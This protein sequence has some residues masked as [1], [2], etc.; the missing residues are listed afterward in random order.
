MGRFFTVLEKVRGKLI[1]VK[2][3]KGRTALTADEVK[4]AVANAKKHKYPV[5]VKPVEDPD[6]HRVVP[7]NSGVDLA[8]VNPTLRYRLE[9]V[10]KDLGVTITATS[11]YR[12]R[13]Q[14]QAL[15][16]LY[17]EGKGPLA[18][19]PGSSNHEK[20]LAVDCFVGS[21]PLGAVKGARAS[22]KRHKLVLGAAGELW[23]IE[24]QES[25]DG[26]RA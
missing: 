25:G 10:A 12:S 26:W 13:A 1:R 11:G 18:A 4:A 16:N 7:Q 21:K 6:A 14:Q 2:N 5:T 9:A 8:H 19:K 17:V 24:L 3:A 20:G 23:H 15:Y 22:M